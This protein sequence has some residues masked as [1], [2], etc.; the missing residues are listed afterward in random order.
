VAFWGLFPW[1]KA[2][3]DDSNP[4]RGESGRPSLKRSPQYTVFSCQMPI[5]AERGN[6]GK[7]VGG[8]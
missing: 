7:R 1:V 8:G 2:P 4:G 6:L 3:G 5:S